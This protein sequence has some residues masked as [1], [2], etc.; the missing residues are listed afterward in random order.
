MN[1]RTC[2]A[3]GFL[4]AGPAWWAGAAD[5][6]PAPEPKPAEEPPKLAP[7][8]AWDRARLHRLIAELTDENY[9]VRQRAQQSL[10]SAPPVY[11]K[12]MLQAGRKHDD[13]D[14]QK[15]LYEAAHAVFLGKVVKHLPQYK[16]ERGF[17]GIAWELHAEPCGVMVN[18]VIPETGAEKAGLKVGDVIVRVERTPITE[19]MTM[20]DVMRIWKGMAPGDT[21]KLELV[22]N[23]ET[24]FIDAPIGEVPQDYRSADAEKP[25]D[26][27]DRAEA[28]WS[29]YL[30][31]ELA[32]GEA[33]LKGKAA[34]AEKPA[35]PAPTDTSEA[36]R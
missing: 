28:L 29:R 31:G 32:I 27:P 34:P 3:L 25:V 26:N 4:L 21:L 18:Q 7:E 35:D 10:A 12:E 6:Q 5:V 13:P 11:L 23:G 9:S 24:L 22:R 36:R 16:L 2:L 15:G 20:E 19:Q 14:A 8:E 1:V 30:S 33:V 17:L